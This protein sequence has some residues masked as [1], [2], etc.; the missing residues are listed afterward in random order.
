MDKKARLLE[1]VME[2]QELY[3]HLDRLMVNDID[4]PN[5]IIVTSGERLEQLASEEGIELDYSDNF[6][7][8]ESEEALMSLIGYDGDD[9]EGGGFIQ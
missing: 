2:L 5:S 8:E 9:D 3:P 4:H 7:D 6:F 1:I